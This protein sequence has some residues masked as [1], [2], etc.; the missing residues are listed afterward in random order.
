MPTSRDAAV[1]RELILPDRLLGPEEVAA[2]LGIPLRTIYRWRSR[3][4]GPRGYRVGRHVRY[5]L[6]DVE[7]WLA[8]RSDTP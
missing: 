4:A 3:H 7:R 2:F 5:R 1:R 8:D 6:D